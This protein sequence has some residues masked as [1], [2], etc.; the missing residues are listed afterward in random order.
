[1]PD[2]HAWSNT[3]GPLS[4]LVECATAACQHA[5]ALRDRGELRLQRRQIDREIGSIEHDPHEEIPGLEVVELL[6]VQNVLPI[7]GE[8]RGNARH[9]AGAIQDKVNTN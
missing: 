2:W 3:A 4:F 8:E 9:D 7:M 5:E 6:G 1:M